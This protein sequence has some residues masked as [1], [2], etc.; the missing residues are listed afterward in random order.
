MA[1][2]AFD[3]GSAGSGA[4]DL[5]RVASEQA[6]CPGL[7]GKHGPLGRPFDLA[8]DQDLLAGTRDCQATAVGDSLLHVWADPSNGFVQSLAT[9]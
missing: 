2:V 3:P 8:I 5:D 4:F 1:F 6:L 9:Q 7:V